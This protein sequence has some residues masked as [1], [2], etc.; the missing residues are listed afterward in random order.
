MKDPKPARTS[1]QPKVVYDCEEFTI[2][3]IPL[4]Y[5]IEYKVLVKNSKGNMVKLIRQFQYWDSEDTLEHAIEAAKE[6]LQKYQDE[7]KANPHAK[8]LL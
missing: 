7:Y 2:S 5:Q 6:S 3:A 8:D 4:N 1:R